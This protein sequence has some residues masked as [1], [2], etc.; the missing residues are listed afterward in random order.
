VAGVGGVGGRGPFLYL[1]E[2]KP[3]VLK[4]DSYVIAQGLIE[5]GGL[6]FGI[7]RGDEWVAQVPFTH[8]GPFAVVVKVPEDAEYKVVLA[9]NLIGT[10]LDN[11]LVVTRAGV[12][13]AAPDG[14][15]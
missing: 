4:K 2:M 6:S 5:K 3:R 8:P 11:R 7:V 14:S 12:I 10:S 15:K 9:N 13:A 1:A